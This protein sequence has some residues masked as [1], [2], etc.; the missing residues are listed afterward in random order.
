MIFIIRCIYVVDQA[1]QRPLLP[2]SSIVISRSRHDG[3]RHNRNQTT[4]RSGKSYKAKTKKTLSR[5]SDRNHFISHFLF[6]CF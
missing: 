6:F 4:R 2:S 3:R 5:L 1:A